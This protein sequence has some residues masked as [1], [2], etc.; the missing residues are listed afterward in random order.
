[1]TKSSSRKQVIIP[2]SLQNNRIMAKSN[3]YITNINRLLKDVKSDILANFMYVDGKSIVITTI[4]YTNL[5][6]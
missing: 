3:I 5:V 4:G 1:M 6:L 2:M